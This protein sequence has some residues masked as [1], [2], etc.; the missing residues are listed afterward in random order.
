MTAQS[1]TVSRLRSLIDLYQ[2][3]YRSALVDQTVGKL[4]ALEIRQLRAELK[5][6]AERMVAYEQ[7]YQM[8]SQEFYERFMAGKLGDEMDLVEWSVFYDMHKATAAR[9]TE[10]EA[11]RP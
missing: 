11:Q 5:R 3:G 8:S 7:R 2:S 10:L 9:L 4:I 6:L 1:Q